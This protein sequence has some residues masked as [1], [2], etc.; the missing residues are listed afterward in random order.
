MT[1]PLASGSESILL[2]ED[3]RRCASSPELLRTRGYHVLEARD[4][5]EA[6][7]VARHG[8]PSTSC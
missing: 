6:L 7:Q 3:E 5:G 1:A 4:A 8:A 2:V